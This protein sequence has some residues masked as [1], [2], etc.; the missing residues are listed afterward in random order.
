MSVCCVLWTQGGS[1]EAVRAVLRSPCSV[2]AKRLSFLS[3]KH[4]IPGLWKSVP[5]MNKVS[6]EEK[7]ALVQTF[8]TGRA[9][10]SRRRFQVYHRPCCATARSLLGH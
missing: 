1:R 4:G 2:R 7:K 3:P 5:F 6:M 9:L 8:M 10:A